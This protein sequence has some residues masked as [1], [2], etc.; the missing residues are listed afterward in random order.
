MKL[1]FKKNEQSEIT[2]MQKTG[3]SEVEFDYVNM[4]KKLINDK[5][6]EKPEIVGDF[7]ESEKESIIAMVADINSEVNKFYTED[8]D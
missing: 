8:E 2:V 5:S 6:L 7:S 3:G 1:I 4:V